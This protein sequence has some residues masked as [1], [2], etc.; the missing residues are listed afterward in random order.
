M[1]LLSEQELFKL[2][3]EGKI[4]GRISPISPEEPPPT[5]VSLSAD[6]FPYILEQL[7]KIQNDTSA[8]LEKIQSDT[9]AM[10]LVGVLQEIRELMKRDVEEVKEL[11]SET[12]SLTK[13]VIS[14]QDKHSKAEWHFS[15]KRDSNGLISDIVATKVEQSN[16]ECLLITKEGVVYYG[17]TIQCSNAQREA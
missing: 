1:K 17:S 9:S 11:K 3:E 14:A 10:A 7:E 8:K 6:K 13:L 5:S 2:R 16:R 12:S 15:I 4:K